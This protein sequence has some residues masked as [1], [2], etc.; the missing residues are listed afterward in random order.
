MTTPTTAT[1][2]TWSSATEFAAAFSAAYLSRFQSESVHKRSSLPSRSGS[3]VAKGHHPSASSNQHSHVQSWTNLFN[4]LLDVS[5]RLILPH[6][7]EPLTKIPRENRGIFV[8]NKLLASASSALTFYFTSRKL[9]S[10]RKKLVALGILFIA[11][12][13]IHNKLRFGSFQ[14]EIHEVLAPQESMPHL[15][16]GF[17]SVMPTGATMSRP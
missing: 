6:H 3:N 16:S 13:A 14:P 7:F 17:I 4:T 15:W 11:A 10:M 9:L 1:S 2:S 12:L 8:L 5:Y